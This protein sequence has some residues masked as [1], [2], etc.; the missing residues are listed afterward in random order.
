MI[1]KN[2]IQNRKTY[3]SVYRLLSRIYPSKTGDKINGVI[4]VLLIQAVL[5]GN[6]IYGQDQKEGGIQIAA[7][8]LKDSIMLRWAPSNYKSWDLG[9]TYGYNIVR[10]TIMRDSVLLEK[11]E[12]TTFT[13]MPLKPLPLNSWETLV[14]S[15]KYGAI[16]A[17]AIYG[18]GFEI[19]A[20]EGFTPE[21]VTNK[22][23]EQQQRFSFA[24]YAADI[25][26]EV[27]KASGLYFVD[28]QA[29]KNEMYLY[30]VFLHLPDSMQNQNDTAFVYT[31]IS[32]YAPLPK[33]IEVIAEF[34][35]KLAV[36]SW[37]IFAQN[38]I[39]IAY[40]VERS[41]NGGKDFF[42]L[43]EEPLIPVYSKENLNPEFTYKYDSLPKN[44]KEYQYRIKGI[45]S[46][47]ETGP[48]SDIVK[49]S[50]TE[51][52][53]AVP[54]IASL[55]VIKNEKVLVRWDFPKEAEKS[56]AGF[57]I[58]RSNN[59][60]T[61]YTE[62]ATNLKP[63][64]REFLDKKPLGTGYYKVVAFRD[65]T[66]KKAS[67]ATM[68][69]L[70]DNTPPESPSGLSGIAD[71][72]G[73]VTLKWKANPD[74]DIYGYRIFRSVS[75]NEEYAQITARP[76]K[77]TNF[78]DTLNKQDLNSSVFYKIIAVD[79]R[80]NESGFSKILEIEKPDIIAPSIPV[81]NETRATEKGILIKWINSTSPDVVGHE[82]FRFVFGDTTWLKIA[83]I[84]LKRGQ[85][86]SEYTDT[87][88]S[89]IKS[90]QYKVFAFDKSG[91]RSVP[92]VSIKIKG[93]KSTKSGNLKK[94][95][96]KVDY[97]N[98]KL[99]LSW[100]LPEKEIK[101]IKIYRK[102]ETKPY[103]LYETLEGTAMKFEDYGMKVGQACIYRIK[104]VYKD[105]SVSGFSD[106]I[107]VNY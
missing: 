35:D 53:K 9:N 88:C 49:G 13:S 66:I 5:F 75:G 12:K 56:I 104:L 92:S 18:K 102:T 85:T 72:N 10:Y 79:Q 29:V 87:E 19:D 27:A 107:K 58:L 80:Q 32:N 76:L 90:N 98:G 31:G 61:G 30:R 54:N 2:K 94:I 24:L 47:G 103:S 37:N 99:W 67:H 71:T 46:F 15:N 95:E 38:N 68:V 63:G 22:S 34:D 44:G 26:P 105:G 60:K 8:P 74:L 86:S 40:Q 55:E 101:Y 21:N 73:L 82:V 81:I 59:H 36:L 62:L 45:T 28:K 4:L 39:Y 20:G 89:C 1:F 52:I 84:E 57:N 96:Q 50:G 23:K 83:E 7:R 3:I 64:I 91:N 51:S 17:Q 106:E 16:A 97:K 43:S 78:T 93:L 41:D 77:G 65:E 70:V 25:S 14:K 48:W 42:A 33:P 100:Q 11:A 6:F 69:Q